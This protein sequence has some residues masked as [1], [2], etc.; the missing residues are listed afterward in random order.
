MGRSSKTRSCRMRIRG[1][2]DLV[3]AG[4]MVY[5]LSPGDGKTMKA[6]VAVMDVSQRPARQVQ[7]SSRRGRGV[8]VWG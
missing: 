1:M 6:A 4:K 5:A 7:N 8:V 2:I 3:A